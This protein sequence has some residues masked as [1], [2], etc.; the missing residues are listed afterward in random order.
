MR[1]N[2]SIEIYGVISDPE[3][4]NVI[5]KEALDNCEEARQAAA[6]ASQGQY[7]DLLAV[8]AYVEELAVS[9]GLLRMSLEDTRMDF[10]DLRSSLRSGDVGYV[11]VEHGESDESSGFRPGAPTETVQQISLHDEPIFTFDELQGAKQVEGGI[12]GLLAAAASACFIPEG[13][14]LVVAPGVMRDWIADY[15]S[16]PNDEIVDGAGLKR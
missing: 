7:D 16:D 4:F 6:E 8:A 13:S 1:S 10:S 5:V 11:Y 3:T 12:D 15:A 14:R 9:G 2:I